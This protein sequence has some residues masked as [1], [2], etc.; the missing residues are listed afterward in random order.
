MESIDQGRFFLAQSMFSSMS[1]SDLRILITHALKDKFGETAS[2]IY[3]GKALNIIAIGPE[4]ITELPEAEAEVLVHALVV[5]THICAI[6]SGSLAE[7]K[8]RITLKV[9]AIEAAQVIRKTH[10]FLFIITSEDQ[11]KLENLGNSTEDRT[12]TVTVRQ[13][14]SSWGYL[15]R[16]IMGYVERID[17]T[18]D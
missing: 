13:N 11:R 18:T 17:R 12:V 10:G 1:G 4:G 3:N 5:F 7:D 16:Q 2:D 15:I 6:L 14:A 9:G 8:V